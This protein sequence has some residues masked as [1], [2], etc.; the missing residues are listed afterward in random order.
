M[1]DAKPK[2]KEIVVYTGTS[3]TREI[4]KKSWESVGIMDQDKVVWDKQTG[5]E[6]PKESLTADALRFLLERERDFT[7]REVPAD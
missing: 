6:V 5:A 1:A 7:V 2:T 4:D 3:T